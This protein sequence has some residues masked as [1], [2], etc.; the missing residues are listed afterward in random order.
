MFKLNE[1][2][3]EAQKAD[4]KVSS[5]KRGWG[6]LLDVCIVLVMGGILFWGAASQ[7][8]NQFNDATRYQCYAVA[9]WNGTPGLGSLPQKQCAFLS[10]TTSSAVAQ[11]L[12][13]RRFPHFLVNLV[14]AQ[15][16]SQPLH[17]LPPE[18]P[19][20]SLVP[21]SLALVVPAAWYQVAFAVW[22]AVVAG[23][24]YFV[25]KP[26]RSTTAAIVFAVYLVIGRWATA[27]GRFDLVTAA[28]T[29]G[30]VILAAKARWKWAFAL[31]ALGTLLKFYPVALVPPLLIAQQMQDKSSK[32]T[33]WRRWSG[34]GVFLAICAGV[35]AFSLVLNVAD[36]LNPFRYF[37]ARPIQVESFPVTLVWL[38]S[39]AV[40]P[41]HVEFAFQSLNVIGPVS[42]E[43]SILS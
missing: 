12:Q 34:L 21:C 6:Y 39:L 27:E 5:L 15:S 42:S 8:Y 16:T 18:Y 7:F 40:Y 37:F 14:A 13:E 23:I 17:A 20:L 30:A 38:G 10:A 1:A 24:I 43:I 28:L 29:L 31:L 26:Y 9:F 32:W 4:D 19:L 25:L 22:M 11:K 36:T 33:S 2:K 41:L 3:A 35:T